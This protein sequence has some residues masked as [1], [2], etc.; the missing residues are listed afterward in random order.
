MRVSFILCLLATTITCR[1]QKA[2]I[3]KAGYDADRKID[4]KDLRSDLVILRTALLKSHPGLFWYQ[5][6]AA[7]ERQFQSLEGDVTAPMTDLQFYTLLTPFISSIR[8]GHTDVEMP[9]AFYQHYRSNKAVFPFRIKIIDAK[10][11][12]VAD[13]S[14][15]GVRPGSQIVSI[16]QTPADSMIARMRPH[17]WSDG[18]TASVTRI[19]LDYFLQPFLYN[20]FS[21][22]EEYALQ[23]KEPDGAVRTVDTKGI[24]YKTY[25]ERSTET[26]KDQRN[27]QFRVIDSLSTAVITIR[28]FMGSG[29][30]SFLKSSFSVMRRQNISNL[31]IDLRGNDGGDGYYGRMLYDRIALE[32][33]KYY[34]HLEMVIED[35][36]DTIFRY[37]EMPMKRSAFKKFHHRKLRNV[38]KGMYYLKN[39]VNRDL[40][41]QPFR[42]ARDNF[43]GHVYVLTDVR[44]ASTTSEFC[45]IAH[46]YKRA[47]FIGRETGGA[48][49]GNT[50]GWEF[51]LTLPASKVVVHIPLIRYYMARKG[52]PGRGVVPNHLIVEDIV[53]YIQNDDPEMDYALQLISKGR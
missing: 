4:V 1:A 11:Y 48:Y 28:S 40:T 2:S 51:K 22:P 16:N 27:Y 52:P 14:G 19:E 47:S 15:E 23:I 43:R 13:F 20:Y 41:D 50:S 24:P 46:S 34:D 37:G 10:M 49:C 45:A 25:Q 12:V 8:C 36:V 17:A 26:Q 18:F 5:D 33:Y 42:P 35:P 39:S 53:R 38:S 29:Y 30:R 6:R 44:C 32:E 31:V 9:D 21:F 7:F 3:D